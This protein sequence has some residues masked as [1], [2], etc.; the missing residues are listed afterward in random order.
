MNE[1]IV[2]KSM[3]L[4]FYQNTYECR[5]KLISI[6]GRVKPGTA[7]GDLTSDQLLHLILDHCSVVLHITWCLCC[8]ESWFSS[9]DSNWY[10]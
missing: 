2:S 1:N 5:K 10:V 9:F 8:S 7:A 6:Y 4:F 3:A